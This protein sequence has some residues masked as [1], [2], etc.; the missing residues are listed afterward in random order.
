MADSGFNKKEYVNT[1]ALIGR[2]LLD[3]PFYKCDAGVAYLESINV[4]DGESQLI[5][6][7]REAVNKFRRTSNN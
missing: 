2:L 4:A 6:Q 3:F 1:Q 7:C 5:Q